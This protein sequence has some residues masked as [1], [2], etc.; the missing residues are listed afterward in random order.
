MEREEEEE[1]E[2]WL[3]LAALRCCIFCWEKGSWQEQFR[4]QGRSRLWD[5]SLGLCSG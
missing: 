1:E 4:G 5:R 2:A 3:E